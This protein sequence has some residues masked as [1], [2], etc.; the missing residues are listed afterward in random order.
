MIKAKTKYVL[1]EHYRSLKYR[2][3]AHNKGSIIF[4]FHK[5]RIRTE[6]SNGK[7]FH[8]EIIRNRENMECDSLWRG[9]AT[10]WQKG[11]VTIL[12]PV[13]VHVS[14]KFG[15]PEKVVNAIKRTF[16]PKVIL[17]NAKNEELRV[18]EKIQQKSKN[19]DT[20]GHHR[21]RI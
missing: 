13:E 18:L 4:W 16:L 19:T 8:A 10:K 12:M 1:G 3:I 14:N 5:N 7:N 15:I 2:Q 21:C 20:I 6:V 11:I 17:I 9:R